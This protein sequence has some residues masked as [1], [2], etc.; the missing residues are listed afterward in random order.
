MFLFET[1]FKQKVQRIIVFI[2]FRL[3]GPI[4]KE[5]SN[6][7]EGGKLLTIICT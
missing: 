1:L 7:L 2:H 6:R 4:S 3:D 5:V